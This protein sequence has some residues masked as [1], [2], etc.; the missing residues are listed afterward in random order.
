MSC[1]QA[2]VPSEK[3]HGYVASS[4]FFLLAIRRLATSTVPE[5][6]SKTKF[7]KLNL[8][9]LNSYLAF[10]HMIFLVVNC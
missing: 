4:C 9:V 7:Y 8:F 10:C 5:C 1:G 6:G 2:F 3:H